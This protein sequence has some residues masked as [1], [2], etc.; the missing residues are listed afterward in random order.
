[1]L[2]MMKVDEITPLQ[3]NDL[4]SKLDADNSGSISYIEFA[5]QLMVHSPKKKSNSIRKQQN[6]EEKS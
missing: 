4:F 3:F 6:A 2:D 5:S 1:M